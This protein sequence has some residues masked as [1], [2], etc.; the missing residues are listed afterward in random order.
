MEKLKKDD[1]RLK[2]RFRESRGGLVSC[3]TCDSKTGGNTTKEGPA[4]CEHEERFRK[5]K[6]AEYWGSC[7][8]N[9]SRNVA[10]ERVCDAYTSKALAE[11]LEIPVIQ[12]KQ[13]ILLNSQ[14]RSIW[15]ADPNCP[16]VVLELRM[17]DD[18]EKNPE[19]KDISK[20]KPGIETIDIS[21]LVPMEVVG[22]EICEMP[23]CESKLPYQ[24]WRIDEYRRKVGIKPDGSGPRKWV[25]NGIVKHGNKFSMTLEEAAEFFNL[26]RFNSSEFGDRWKQISTV[27]DYIH[28]KCNVLGSRPLSEAVNPVRLWSAVCHLLKD[29]LA[30]SDNDEEFWFYD[31]RLF[32][33][34][35]KLEK[36]P[37]VLEKI[38]E[39]L[40]L[41]RD[42]HYALRK[43]MTSCERHRCFSE[44]F[45]IYGVVKE[46]EDSN[47]LS[48]G[49][50]CFVEI[51]EVSVHAANHMW[52]EF[53]KG[54]GKMASFDRE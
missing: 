16:Y 3:V 21:E 42:V 13:A 51:Y 43:A 20:G 37:N 46:L 6:I 49:L 17:M 18:K 34:E 33:P 45:S 19:E 5:I 31:K 53:G 9:P 22:A 47:L 2:Y 27:A 35:I 29:P 40:I 11:G 12:E 25:R 44:W 7:F 32:N 28:K 36:S 26:E 50:S 15:H 54:F 8:S 10:A 1:F 4:F 14:W 30:K 24:T 39:G 23:C 41:C 52:G 38:P 48:K